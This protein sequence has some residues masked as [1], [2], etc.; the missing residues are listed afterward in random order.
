[1][2][3]RLDPNEEDEGS[4]PFWGTSRGGVTVARRRRNAIVKVR[5][6]SPAPIA[7]VAQWNERALGKGEVLGSIPSVG[8]KWYN[9]S[10]GADPKR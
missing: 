4:T 6:L 3:E 1:M 10:I 5:V 7:Y 2:E 9:T 8:S